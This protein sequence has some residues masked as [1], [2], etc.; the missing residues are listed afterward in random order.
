M[1]Q[2]FLKLTSILVLCNAICVVA[3]QNNTTL[4]TFRWIDVTKSK[5]LDFQ[6]DSFSFLKNNEYF[7]NI[8]DGYTLFGNQFSPKF[9]YHVAPNVTIEG[10]AYLW[11]D[12]GNE[13]FT[14][15][16]PIFSV[17]VQKDSSQ[18][19]FGNLEG[20]LNHHLVEPMLNFERVILNRQENGLQYT[21]R[22]AKTFFDSWIDWQSMIY[23]GSAFQEAI[24][25]G[26]SW[27]K[28]IIRKPRLTVSLPLQ[29]TFKHKGGQ[30][31]TDSNQV[32]TNINT[33]LGL[34][35]DYT[36]N[37]FLKNIKLQNYW[38]GFVH[39]AGNHP[40]FANGN[41]L[42]LNLSTQTR[43][44]NLMVSYWKGN[45]YLSDTGGDLYQSVGNVYKNP[46][47][48]EKNRQL[49]IF[50][51]MKDWKIIDNVALTFRFEPY[52]DLNNHT[53]EHAESLFLTYRQ[54][55]NIK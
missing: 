12:F 34:E 19:L 7:G 8:A 11:K 27:N 51:V 18:F 6:F 20:N 43:V 5:Q 50:R 54:V 3:Q 45:S 39:N 44:L 24:F 1:L 22:N 25:A 38:L 41:G 55:F 53:F 13:K 4:E 52:L 36:I 31:S 29:M 30:I 42:Y 2:R 49:L 47:V 9:I 16:Q 40:Y 21:K 26:F 14:T 37:G 32:V 23:K 46:N 17:R 35:V 48:I 15:I 10:G 33:A 28:K